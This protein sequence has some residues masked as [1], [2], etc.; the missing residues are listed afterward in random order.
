MARREK[1]DQAA[2]ADLLDKLDLSVDVEDLKLDRL[3]LSILAVLLAQGE[4]IMAN[5]DSINTALASQT[6]A[7]EALGTEVTQLAEQVGELNADT[8][9]QEELDAIAASMTTVADG[10]TSAAAGVDAI[11]T[12]DD[13]EPE[14]EP[15]PPTV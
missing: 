13:A 2:L 12:T 10:I 15:E 9:T 5:L 4:L 14:P 6:A 11:V 3:Q 1:P 7:L 8:V